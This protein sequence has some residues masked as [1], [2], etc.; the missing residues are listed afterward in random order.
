MIG[1]ELKKGFGQLKGAIKQGI[2]N[3]KQN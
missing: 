2:D 3:V 1:G